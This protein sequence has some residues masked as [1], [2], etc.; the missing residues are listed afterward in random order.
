MVRQGYGGNDTTVSTDGAFLNKID[1]GQGMPS[2][3]LSIQYNFDG[4]AN[5]ASLVTGTIYI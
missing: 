3:Q 5:P 4:T 1:G 2:T